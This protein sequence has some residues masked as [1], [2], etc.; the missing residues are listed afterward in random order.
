[1]Q[2]K[3][4][5]RAFSN[6]CGFAV[7]KC[8]VSWRRRWQVRNAPPHL[9]FPT[10]IVT[11]EV[12]RSAGVAQSFRPRLSVSSLLGA[13]PMPPVLGRLLARGC[14]SVTCRSRDRD[15]LPYDQPGPGQRRARARTRLRA[16][17]T[18]LRLWSDWPTGNGQSIRSFSGWARVPA[19]SLP[20]RT[21]A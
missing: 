1:M 4:K 2:G 15:W 6:C 11:E 16:R 18:W 5:I 17:I 13:I 12:A 7:R 19:S 3:G 20:S 14:P 9:V 8:R 10:R 21:A